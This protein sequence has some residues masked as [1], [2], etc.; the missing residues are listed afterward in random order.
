MLEGKDPQTGRGLS[1]ENIRFQMITF[2]TAGHETTSGLLTFTL[3]ELLDNPA[4]LAKA[5]G[6]VDRVLGN[7]NPRFEHLSQLTYIDQVLKETLRLWPIASAFAVQPYENETTIGGKYRVTQDQVILVFLPA[8]HR[9][10]KVW[11]DPERFDPERF[12]PGNV[13]KIPENAWKAFGNGQRACIGRPFALQ[14]ATAA[15]AGILQ[16]FEISKADPDYQLRIK[17][18]ATI[19]PEGFFIKAKRRNVGHR[20]DDSGRGTRCSAESG[21]GDRRSNRHS[22]ASIV[23]LQQRLG[24]GFRSA[25]CQRRQVAWLC[26]DP[27]HTR[28]RGGPFAARRSSGHRHRLLRRPPHG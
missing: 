9:D 3:Y 2:L 6:E 1:D 16:R 17:E 27:R 18:T 5:R 14:E 8:L 15:L 22:A 13:E 19:K 24:R 12:A 4:C 11:V 28:F 7:Q 23:R 26:L 25:N 20:L 10:P 21:S